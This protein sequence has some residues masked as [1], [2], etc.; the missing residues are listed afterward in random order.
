MLV[1]GRNGRYFSEFKFERY[2][3]MC[4]VEVLRLRCKCSNKK[5]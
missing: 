2:I 5:S 4:C 1:K 3:L